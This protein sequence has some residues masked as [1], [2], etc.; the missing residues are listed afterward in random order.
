MPNSA[1]NLL[2]GA[3]LLGRYLVDLDLLAPR[4]TFPESEK[5]ASKPAQS[6]FGIPGWA[7]SWMP[8][9]RDTDFGFIKTVGIRRDLKPS[10]NSSSRLDYEHR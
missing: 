3:N 4:P 1:A 7:W 8:S 6:I 5:F 2:C 9:A 10:C